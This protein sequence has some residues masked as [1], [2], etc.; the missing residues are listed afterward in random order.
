MRQLLG[1]GGDAGIGDD[2]DAAARK[3][4]AQTL[5]DVAVKGG[6]DFLAELQHG[7]LYAECGEDG[8]ELHADDSAA[9][10]GDARWEGVERQEG[11][12]G[13]GKLCAGDGELRGDGAGGDDQAVSHVLVL[14]YPHR[15]T[16]GGEA[17]RATHDV[18]L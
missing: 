13:H 1:D 18:D 16:G 10:D 15:G 4:A 14:P 8:G 17:R 7:H 12:G 9:D 3:E 6:Q 5:G 2:A 11:V